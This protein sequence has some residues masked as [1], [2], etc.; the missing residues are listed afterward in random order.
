MAAIDFRYLRF[1][2]RLPIHTAI[3]FVNGGSIVLSGAVGFAII[4]TFVKES[5]AA[6]N[7]CCDHVSCGFTYGIIVAIEEGME[8]IG[9]TIF[10]NALS[11]IL[12]DVSPRVE[13]RFDH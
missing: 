12:L 8:M 6:A 13:L 3:Q 2:L 5:T 1:L 4:G 10:S 9:V 7:S 11:H